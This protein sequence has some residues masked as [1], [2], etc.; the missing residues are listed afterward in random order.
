MLRQTGQLERERER[1]IFGYTKAINCL[2][3][4]ACVHFGGW[5]T[6]RRVREFAW[7]QRL[8]DYHL[9]GMVLRFYMMLWLCIVFPEWFLFDVTSLILISSMSPW[10]RGN[11][12]TNPRR[13]YHSSASRASQK[14]SSSF[15]VNSLIWVRGTK[16]RTCNRPR[17]EFKKG[18]EGVFFDSDLGR[19]M[20]HHWDSRSWRK[21][22]FFFNRG[23][24]VVFLN[25]ICGNVP[26][27]VCQRLL[28]KRLY[29]R[30][31]A[32]PVRSN[33]WKMAKD[34]SRVESSKMIM[35]RRCWCW[36]AQNLPEVFS[37]GPRKTWKK[38]ARKDTW[39]FSDPPAI[40]YGRRKS[41]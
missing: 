33:W 31:G 3:S 32:K 11:D 23:V 37:I 1:E 13:Q 35:T 38:G 18:F 7:F 21:Q 36:K 16:D 10:W 8:D 27:E 19:M 40:Y 15:N 24:V 17:S 22:N 30:T 28:T 26:A 12:G 39:H 9:H 5:H 6:F 14:M 20:Q 25:G 34:S 29:F 4:H 41:P 2:S